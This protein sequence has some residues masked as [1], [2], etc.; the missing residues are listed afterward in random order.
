MT[1]IPTQPRHHHNSH[2]SGAGRAMSWKDV[3]ASKRT[4]QGRS[5]RQQAVPTQRRLHHQPLRELQGTEKHGEP[6]PQSHKHAKANRKRPHA[7]AKCGGGSTTGL[8]NN[9]Y[10]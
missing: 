4:L 10:L 1:I 2:I 8:F 9:R 3:S 5:G 7:S 6:Q